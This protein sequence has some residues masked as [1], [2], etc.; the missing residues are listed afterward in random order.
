M[1]STSVELDPQNVRPSVRPKKPTMIFVLLVHFDLAEGVS[2]EQEAGSEGWRPFI[3]AAVGCVGG[4]TGICS[5]P[6]T[7]YHNDA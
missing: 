4:A 2:Q 3:R 1:F 6:P 7:L 5:R